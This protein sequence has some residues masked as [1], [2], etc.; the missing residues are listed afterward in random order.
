MSGRTISTRARSRA[1]AALAVLGT[2]AALGATV[3]VGA[4]TAGAAPVRDADPGAA[5][6]IAAQIVS[7]DATIRFTTAALPTAEADTTMTAAAAAAAVAADEQAATEGAMAPSAGT[8]SV[9]SAA[10]GAILDDLAPEGA[11]AARLAAE[12]AAAAAIVRRDELKN[13][14]VTATQQKA[15]LIASLQQAGQRRTSWC[16]ALLDWL[17]APVTQQNLNALFSWIDAESNAASLLNPLA[18]TQGAPGA[19]NANHVGVKGYPSVEVGLEATVITLNNGNY[20]NILAALAKGD[21][22]R[23]VTEAVAASPWG[24]GKNATIRLLADFGG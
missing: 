6:G 1:L 9:S 24:T 13:A 4:R 3:A 22:A 10:S 19:R 23:A 21:S 16:V 7:A 18:T 20:A 2:L 11:S 12:S 15:S 5:A 14:L 8:T 17:G